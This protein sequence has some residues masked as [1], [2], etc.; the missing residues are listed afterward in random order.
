VTLFG[1]FL[2]PVFFSVILGLSETRLF[3]S[4]GARW[5]GSAL[6]GGMLGLAM[7]FLLARLGVAGWSWALGIGGCAGVLAA[8]AAVGVHV[9]VARR[10]TG[11]D[12]QG[13]LPGGADPPWPLGGG[14]P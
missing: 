10:L 5:V 6:M 11:F 13:D 12:G 9:T 7:G 3:M 8:L 14:P 2:T 4:A 1:I